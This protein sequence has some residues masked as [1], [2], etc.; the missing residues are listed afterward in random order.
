MISA[1][2]GKGTVLREKRRFSEAK[3]LLLRAARL[4]ASTRRHRLAAE[5]QHDLFALAVMDGSYTEAENHMASALEHY[6][7]HHPGIPGLVHDWCFLL[8]QCRFYAQ[9]VPLLQASIPHVRKAEIQLVSWGILSRA[10][11]GAGSR[12][13]YDEALRHVRALVARTHEFAAAALAHA[14]YGAR[15]FEEWAL[16]E[17]LARQSREIAETRAET[18]VAQGVEEF[19]TAIRAKEAPLPQIEPPV[20]SRIPE[21]A[22]RMTTLLDARRRPTRR[23]VEPTQER[24]AGGPLVPARRHE[25]P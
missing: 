15:F 9:A 19:L 6:P 1:L 24:E 7:V 25:L 18:E 17:S 13:L 21:I 4:C 5:T 23:P 14:A 8:V 12:E 11:A 2:L 20:S 22:G 16:A 10:A 3:S